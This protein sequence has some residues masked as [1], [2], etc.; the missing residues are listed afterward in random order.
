LF[1]F[2]LALIP[3][4]FIIFGWGYQPERVQAIVFFVI[5]LIVWGFLFFRRIWL[6]AELKIFFYLIFIIKISRVCKVLLFFPFL[7][8]LPVFF[9]HFWLPKAHVEAP[10]FGSIVLA[11]VLLKMGGYG[12]FIIVCFLGRFNCVYFFLVCSLVCG[13]IVLFQRDLKRFI[14]YSSVFHMTMVFLV[15]FV[16][17]VFRGF[18]RIF[19][20]SL[21]SV[22]ASLLFIF[23]SE[24]YYMLQ[25]RNFNFIFGSI[26]FR[27]EFFMV[28]F[29][30]VLFLN[31]GAPP[32]MGFFLRLECFIYF[33]FFLKV[34]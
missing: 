26:F 33:W 17:F 7:V 5:Y 19:I 16:Q 4:F 31:L 24:I 10:V 30:L 32:L 13:L 6:L 2:E 18:I 25:T 11:R 3:I 27:G 15:I 12:I 1:F 34:E 14:A 29:Y 20:L 28:F 23:S 9:F 21:H 8:K 22:T